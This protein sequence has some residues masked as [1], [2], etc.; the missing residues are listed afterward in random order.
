MILEQEILP[1]LPNYKSGVIHE[2][3]DPGVPLRRRPAPAEAALPIGEGV[4]LLDLRPPLTFASEFVPGSYS[5]SDDYCVRLAHSVAGQNALAV[6]TLGGTAAQL[7]QVE[8]SFLAS[9]S[10]IEHFGHLAVNWI[11]WRGEVGK[12]EVI[13]AEQL[14][15]RILG[16]NTT[17]IDL[18]NADQ[19]KSAHTREAL[20]VPV[21]MLDSALR[22]LPVS[23]AVSVVS[24]STAESA[25]GASIFFRHGF[26]SLSI[27]RDGFAHYKDRGLPLDPK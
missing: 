11:R 13:E 20:N 21:A 6:Q 8:A 7:A 27:L 23:T 24:N 15:I 19:F 14:A 1:R 5:A 25:F 2:L 22:G 16:W 3:N 26:R 17:V 18:R 10:S 12:I 9:A 4:V